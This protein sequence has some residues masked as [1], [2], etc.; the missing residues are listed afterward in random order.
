MRPRFDDRDA[1]I[2][3]ERCR[4]W[5]MRDGPRVGDFLQLKNGALRRVAHINGDVIQT[6]SNGKSDEYEFYLG[7][8]YMSFSGEVDKAIP[9]ATLTRLPFARKGACWLYHQD[10]RQPSN[11][12]VST[13][14]NCRVYMEV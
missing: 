6:A 5:E 14:V 13:S 12:K 7:T 3:A 8:G 11:P 9:K 4:L 2:V 1:R 10:E